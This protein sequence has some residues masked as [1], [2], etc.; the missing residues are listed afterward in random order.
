MY[1]SQDFETARAQ[2]QPTFISKTVH[3]QQPPFCLFGMVHHS[4]EKDFV[5]FQKC[6]SSDH[7]HPKL[8]HFKSDAL[9]QERHALADHDVD[10]GPD[11]VPR[12]RAILAKLRFAFS[13]ERAIERE[14]AKTKRE[15]DRYQTTA[16]P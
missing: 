12:I 10:F 16:M 2:L 9:Q 13:V 15:V 7:P 4:T 6:M 3:W 1:M 11:D 8:Q 14:H 5:C